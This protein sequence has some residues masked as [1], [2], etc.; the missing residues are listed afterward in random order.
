VKKTPDSRLWSLQEWPRL[1]N[2]DRELH[3]SRWRGGPTKLTLRA[4]C[5]K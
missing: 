4:A 5:G 2:G 3:F 1:R